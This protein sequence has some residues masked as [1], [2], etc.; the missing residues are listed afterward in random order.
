MVAAE[1]RAAA[2]ETRARAAEARVAAA[3]ARAVAAETQARAAQEDRMRAYV[4][5][6]EL[7]VE[8]SGLLAKLD[9]SGGGRGRCGCARRRD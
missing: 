8:T 3:E 2:A 5:A 6:S 7:R 1:A 9:A 4:T